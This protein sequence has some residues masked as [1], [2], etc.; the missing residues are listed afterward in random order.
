[1]PD[2]PHITWPFQRA[3]NGKVRVTEQDSPQ[4]VASCEWAIIRCPLGF[5]QERPDFGWPFPTFA[6]FPLDLTG[7][8]QALK[9]FEPRS[10]AKVTQSLDPDD[11]SV[12]HIEVESEVTNSG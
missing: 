5:R 6:D 1:M 2:I 4:H 8:Q 11:P 7:L 10:T 9:R 3:P 12:V